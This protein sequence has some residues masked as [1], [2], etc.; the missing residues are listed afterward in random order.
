MKT[1]LISL[2]TA[3]LLGIAAYVTGPSFGA[4]ELI[5][6]LFVAGLVAWTFSLY[7]PKPR[8]QALAKPIHLPLRFSAHNSPGHVHQLAA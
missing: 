8:L 7:G 1:V 6:I 2:S 4:D 3:A 5:S